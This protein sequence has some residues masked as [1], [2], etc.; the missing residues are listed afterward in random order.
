MD[1]LVHNLLYYKSRHS[2]Y[3]QWIVCVFLQRLLLYMH[4]ME[5]A[6]I[7]CFLLKDILTLFNNFLG[8]TK[9]IS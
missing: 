5:R 2:V 6:K 7:K 3:L 9:Q 4:C 1:E 8:S